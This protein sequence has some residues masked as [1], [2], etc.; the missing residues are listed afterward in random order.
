M[1]LGSFSVRRGSTP[2]ALALAVGQRVRCVRGVAPVLATGR[3]Y[4][5]AK[6]VALSYGDFVVLADDP[7][8]LTWA[9]DRFEPV[10]STLINR[11]SLAVAL[12]AALLLVT[13][14]FLTGVG[15]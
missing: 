15:R 14:C 13:A 8:E 7:Q 4:V 1:R 10:P 5:V 6:V 11:D 2:V 3:E 9:V 12:L